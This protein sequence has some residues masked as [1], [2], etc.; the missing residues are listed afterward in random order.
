MYDVRQ[1]EEDG[2]IRE[3]QSELPPFLYLYDS[4]E[5]KTLQST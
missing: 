2:N 3:L 5:G 1:T 4:Q